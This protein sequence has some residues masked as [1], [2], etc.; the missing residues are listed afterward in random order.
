MRERNKPPFQA[1]VASVAIITTV[2]VLIAA[3]VSFMVL[4]WSVNLQQQK[5]EETTLTQVIAASAAPETSRGRADLL[6]QEAATASALKDVVDV[7]IVDARGRTLG[8]FAA[9]PKVGQ[10]S[11]IRAVE[12]PMTAKGQVIGRVVLRAHE[13]TIIGLLPRFV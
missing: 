5:V 9:P 6:R 1:R 4:Q 8:Y 2:A 7:R 3:C 11:P 10:A 13:A 12:A